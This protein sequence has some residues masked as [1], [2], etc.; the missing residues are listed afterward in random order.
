MISKRLRLAGVLL[1]A[2]AASSLVVGCRS[3]GKKS[4]YEFWKKDTPVTDQIWTD[5]EMIPPPPV[6]EQPGM[7]PGGM[8]ELPPI[9]DLGTGGPGDPLGMDAP[10]PNPIRSEAVGGV[11]ELRTVYFAYDSDALGAQ[12]QATLDGNARWLVSNPNVEVQV[13]GHCDERGSPEYNMSLGERRAANVR[14]YLMARGVAGNR[15]IVIS[16]G[17]ERPVALGHDEA[18][19][20][21]NRR[22]Q[23]MVYR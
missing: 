1:T 20:A 21:Q 19:W 11:S 5:D 22:V 10:L 9:T 4:W 8:I 3:D 13:E 6:M 12:A 23:F 16:Y 7:G 2:I 18:S 14:K 17:E 15:L